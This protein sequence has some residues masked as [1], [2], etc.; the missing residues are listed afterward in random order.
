MKENRLWYAV[1]TDCEDDWGYGSYDYEEAVDM[2]MSNEKYNLIAVI[3]NDVCIEEI[4]KQDL[5]ENA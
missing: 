2:I 3:E 5:I 1:Q 4:Y